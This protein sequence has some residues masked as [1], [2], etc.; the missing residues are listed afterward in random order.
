MRREGKVCVTAGRVGTTDIPLE[1]SRDA[2][3]NP[4]GKMP[5]GQRKHFFGL[6]GESRSGTDGPVAARNQVAA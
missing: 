2:L 6:G 5:S 1:V 3:T 4:K